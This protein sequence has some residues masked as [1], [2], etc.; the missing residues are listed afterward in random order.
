MQG[1][2]LS[3]VIK[4]TGKLIQEK[5]VSAGTH[6][7][8]LELCQ[9][10]PAGSSVLSDERETGAPL[11]RDPLSSPRVLEFAESCNMFSVSTF[12]YKTHACLQIPQILG[13]GGKF[14]QSSG[15]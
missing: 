10:A 14:G 4:R 12:L 15:G 7:L 13:D 5:R 9:D 1:I 3:S 11:L 8:S 6:Q 2:S